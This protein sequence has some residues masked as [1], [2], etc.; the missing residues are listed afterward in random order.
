MVSLDKNIIAFCSNDYLGLTQHP[1]VISAFK[2]AADHYGVGSG[3]SCL[4]T[5]Y[6]SPH[7]ECEEAFADFLQRDR[8]VLFSNGYMANLGVMQALIKSDDFIFQD[9]LNHASLID[10]GLSSKS[11]FKRYRHNNLDHLEKLLAEK[12]VQAKAQEKT[13]KF[14]I[15]DSLFSMD[16][17]LANIPELVK[18]AEN[19]KATLMVDDAHGIGVLGKTGRGV[20]EH[21]NL[22][23]KD[24]PILVC[25]LGKA[26]GSY[27]AIVSGSEALIENLIQ[28]SRSYI[29]TTGLP[30]AIAAAT[31]ASLEI[32]KSEPWRR[33][34]LNKLINYFKAGA[35]ERN[36]IFLPSSSP[37]QSFV[38]GDA[39]KTIYL[40]EALLAKKLFVYAIRPPTVLPNTSR[41]RIT[42][43]CNHQEAEIDRLLDCLKEAY[44]HLR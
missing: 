14:I 37:I 27:G 15:T 17:D 19:C 24:V 2:K 40:S 26:L 18:L 32:I 13:Q 4:I 22:S 36:L 8:A 34:K 28:F 41:L 31:I 30:P 12:K 3:A 9:K 21:F 20:I 16:G 39:N 44:E 35:A 25:P 11:Q 5:G 6:K 7:Q 29:Y 42:L 33:E 10:A 1:D 38:V 23:Q 43:N